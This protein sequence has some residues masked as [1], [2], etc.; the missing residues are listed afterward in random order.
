MEAITVKGVSRELAGICVPGR[1]RAIFQLSPRDV[2]LTL[3]A[4]S[5]PHVLLSVHPARP[6]L[7]ATARKMTALP[8]P[9]AFCRLL[10]KHLV[11]LVL[12]GVK[13]P[14]MERSVEFLFAPSGS[15]APL[16]RLVVEIMGR[17]SNILLVDGGTGVIVDSLHHVPPG[18]RR[19][20][21][22][23]P[24]EPWRPP[25]DGGR[26]DLETVSAGDFEEIRRLCSESGDPLASRLVGLGPGLLALAEGT[27]GDLLPSFR[28]IIE[29]VRGGELNPV[30]Y[31]AR[32]RLLPLPVPAWAEEGP[33]PFATL[34]EG[35][36]HAFRELSEGKEREDL[37]AGLRRTLARRRGRLLTKRERLEREAGEGG[38]ELELQQTGQALL[39]VLR[40]IPRGAASFTVTDHS[41]PGAPP[42][43]VEL[44]P[45]LSP[46]QNA[47]SCFRRARKARR[48]ADLARKGLHP[49]EKELSRLDTELEALEG[50]SLEELRSLSRTPHP[51]RRPGRGR[52][53]GGSSK[54]REYR[55]GS[56]WRILVGKSSAG[57]DYLT[58]RVA[59][60]EDFWFHTRDYPGAHVVLK[61]PGTA[62]EPP[63]E[64]LRAAGEAAAWHSAAR[65]EATADV[66]FTRRKHVR[67]VKGQ[68]RGRVLLPKSRTLRVRPR[69]PEGFE[70][71]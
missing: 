2:V 34:C 47:E 15:E 11:G 32:K 41:R 44:D 35:A 20:R 21:A 63:E 46:R 53:G 16:F 58:S 13:S 54:I 48:R 52:G 40:E 50:L 65:S 69:V 57:N 66:S 49:L 24:G 14:S 10:R 23:L 68:P 4:G 64:L 8:S 70:E 28:R 19:T 42:R 27:G 7:F 59:Q 25:P 1:V 45:A 30:Y 12:T 71:V 26:R 31:P 43:V 55:S 67:K 51:A 9:S 5:A 62:G 22:V 18:S 37:Q 6:S 17:W 60:P 36:E 29:T 38:S 3:G 56:G 33:L 61:A 39:A